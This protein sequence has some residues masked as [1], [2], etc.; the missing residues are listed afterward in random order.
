MSPRR[1][2]DTINFL[3]ST[4][5]S[6]SSDLRMKIAAMKISLELNAFD[7]DT[8]AVAIA[9]HPYEVFESIAENSD[10]L[11]DEQVL[12]C[13]NEL[14]NYAKNVGVITILILEGYNVCFSST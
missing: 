11:S 12:I 1:R 8:F 13:W 7:N 9:E 14:L 10:L 5:R 3:L 2:A 6:G 4:Q